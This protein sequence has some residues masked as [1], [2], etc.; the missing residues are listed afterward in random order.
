MK[1][2]HLI[3]L[4]KKSGIILS[5][6]VLVFFL[7]SCG[8]EEKPTPLP[9]PWL[10][11]EG[12]KVVDGQGREV[13]LRGLQLAAPKKPYTLWHTREDF[14][15]LKEWGFS[16]IRLAIVWAAL[17][18]EPGVINDDYIEYIAER[19]KWAAELGI[20]TV[21][22]MHQDLYSEKYC[23][24]GAPEW[25][26]LDEGIEFECL[27]PWPLNYYQ[28]A[29]IRA[30]DNFWKNTNGVQDHFVQVWVAV[31]ERFK[32]EPY[33]AGYDIIN[34]PY[35]GSFG[36]LFG[37]PEFDIKYLQPFYERTIAAIRKVDPYHIIFIEPN[38]LRDMGI[39]TYMQRFDAPNLMYSPHVYDPYIV[40]FGKYSGNESFIRRSVNEIEEEA[41]RL[42]MPW[43]LG[44]FG[45]MRDDQVPG[46][47]DYIGAFLDLL[48]ERLVG[49][50]YWSFDKSEGQTVLWPDGSEKPFLN[51]LV[52][53]YPVF[54]AGRVRKLSFSIEEK[55]FRLEFESKPGVTGVSEIFVPQ[56]RHYPD[57]FQISTDLPGDTF[58]FDSAASRLIIYE[59]PEE[60]VHYLE[61]RPLQ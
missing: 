1:A 32:D 52:R 54:F 46:Q 43:W 56:K 38:P 15:K 31:A 22:D 21:L 24:D 11:V 23:G 28:P 36:T 25:A 27:S 20:Y 41:A 14:Q 18:P 2:E 57:G 34:E 39:P 47:L 58:Y 48:D 33:I 61:I 29:V 19:V 35:Y 51:L 53:P 9:G 45:T 10:H 50:L 30:F 26:C 6:M 17:E 55:V 49:W 8:E 3:F 44:E 37:A 13:L 40:A 59:I 12:S 4:F 60:G 5:C 42:G 7:G 16:V